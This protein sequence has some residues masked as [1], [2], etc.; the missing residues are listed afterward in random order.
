MTNP[1]KTE[2]DS[3]QQSSQ[4][5]ERGLAILAAI[6]ENR[7]SAGIAELARSVD[8]SKSTVHRYVATL[9]RL[10]YLE[11]E[12]QSRKYYLGRVSLEFAYA[13]IA[14][15]DISRAAAMPLQALADETGCTVNLA[16]LDGTDIVYVDRRRPCMLSPTRLELNTNVGS[17]L[18][19]YCTSMGKVLLAYGDPARVRGILDRTDLARRGPKTITTREE[20][21]RDLAEVARTGLGVNDEELAPGL[22][23]IAAPVRDRSAQVVAAVN[24]SVH[25]GAWNATIE[26]VQRRFAPPLLRCA[27][28]LSKR[29]GY[30]GR[31]S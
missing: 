14:S 10:G 8:L 25:L 12:E 19:S 30:L 24:L 22:R 21:M 16:I 11:Q 17:R 7:G 3:V 18:P 27:D 31:V 5:L 29:M 6:G 13:A 2:T 23:S 1:D 4:V 15:L 26:A 20:L 9:V 28:E